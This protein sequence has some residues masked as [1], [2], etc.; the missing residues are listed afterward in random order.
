VRP[1]PAENVTLLPLK[2]RTLLL[3]Y[4]IPHELEHFSPGLRFSVD[5][6]SEFDEP[7]EWKAVDTSDF[8]HQRIEF[9]VEIP[10]LLPYALYSVRVRLLSA[11][12]INKLSPRPPL[13]RRERESEEVFIPSSFFFSSSF[14]GGC[15]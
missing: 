13:G 8:D 2:E 15:E 1:G 11:K 14:S 10:G 3:G 5:F 9:S 12:V 4:K 6:R 7:G